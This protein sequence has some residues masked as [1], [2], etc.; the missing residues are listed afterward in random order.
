M[1]LPAELDALRHAPPSVDTRTLQPGDLFF[2][3][4]GERD[5][6]E[7]AAQ[8]L[9][10]GAVAV[11]A[12]H[13]L[14]LAGRVIV[15]PDTLAALQE[16]AARVRREWAGVLVAVTGS[17]GKTTTKD[18]IAGL[19]ATVF[20]TGKSEG[21]FNNHIGVPLS[22]LRLPRTCRVGVIEIGMNHAGEIRRLA[23]IA[24][25]DIAVVTNVGNAHVE[26]FEDGIE[27][28]ALAKRELIEALPPEG[29][30]ILNADDERVIRFRDHHPGRTITFGL[31]QAADVHPDPGPGRGFSVN[32]VSFELP[33]PG[34]HDL[35]NVLAGLAVAR[36]FEIPFERLRDAVRRLSPGR[37]RGEFITRNGIT[38]INDCYNSNPEAARAMLDLLANTPAERRVAVLGEMLELGRASERFHREVG[39]YAARRAD[40]LV[41][42]RGQ[43]THFVEGAVAAGM[44]RASAC[45]FPTPEEAGDFLKAQL[46]A[47]DAV[48]FKGSRGVALEKALARFEE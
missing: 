46:R 34:R 14:P 8:A 21:N 43:A 28:V 22:L 26:N 6:H 47:G 13:A 4:R 30:A 23:A 32:G 17:A 12:D 15:V 11:V 24:R 33:L 29:I 35:L 37:M 27:G 45:F 39:E 40:L 7:F 36:A 18:I 44:P 48:L 25:P 38:I 10:K 42:V 20:P 19:L 1:S 2:A 5:G 9:E 31:S 3:L 16:L 41:A